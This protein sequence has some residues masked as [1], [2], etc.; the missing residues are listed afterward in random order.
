MRETGDVCRQDADLAQGST[1][2][3]SSIVFNR[4]AE[5][6]YTYRLRLAR[7]IIIAHVG[8]VRLNHGAMGS[9]WERSL[10]RNSGLQTKLER[11]K[12]ANAN[13]PRLLLSATIL[14]SSFFARV[15]VA[16]ASKP[17]DCINRCSS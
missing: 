17:E 9:M 5:T 14:T 1:H 6:R 15:A 4:G 10:L 11:R 3:S 16:S 12:C 7:T 13:L 8:G 2:F